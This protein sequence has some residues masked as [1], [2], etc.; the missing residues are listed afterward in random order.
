M[1]VDL[2]E[3]VQNISPLS[4]PP[5]FSDALGYLSPGDFIVFQ[6]GRTQGAERNG[7]THEAEPTI[8]GEDMNPSQ[9]LSVSSELSCLCCHLCCMYA[10]RTKHSYVSLQSTHL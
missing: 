1:H 3:E 5:V 8:N 10:T 7:D 9:N 6:D 2:W 4:S